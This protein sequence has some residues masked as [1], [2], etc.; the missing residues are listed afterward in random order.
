MSGEL[1]ITVQHGE[2][3]PATTTVSEPEG[4]WLKA[5]QVVQLIHLELHHFQ[6]LLYW[7]YPL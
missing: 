7:I 3:V 1:A 2:D 6:Y 4:H 5:P